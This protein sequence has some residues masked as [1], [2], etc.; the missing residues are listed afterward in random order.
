MFCIS[1]QNKTKDIQNRCIRQDLASYYF[2]KSGVECAL[3]MYIC[4]RWDWNKQFGIKLEQ[5]SSEL[6]IKPIIKPDHTH[7]LRRD[8]Q[9]AD[10]RHWTCAVMI[11]TDDHGSRQM[12]VGQKTWHANRA[13]RSNSGWQPRKFVGTNSRFHKPYVKVRKSSICQAWIS[14]VVLPLWSKRNWLTSKTHW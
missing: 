12:K 14:I 3:I 2:N 6:I 11:T 8:V 9:H 4:D 5:N 7:H 10:T 1:K 13:E